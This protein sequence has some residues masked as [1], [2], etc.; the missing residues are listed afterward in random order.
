M[1]KYAVYLI[2]LRA[3]QVGEFIEI[4]HKKNSLSTL[5]CLWLCD[6]DSEAI[7]NLSKLAPFTVGPWIINYPDPHHSQ[8]ALR[9]ATQISPLL[10][11]YWNLSISKLQVEKIKLKAYQ[12]KFV[13]NS[14]PFVDSQWR[15]R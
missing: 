7:K 1:F 11:F 13:E 12:I 10:N 2:P 8:G 6:C 9:F 4:R 5:G 14:S 15:C 3:K